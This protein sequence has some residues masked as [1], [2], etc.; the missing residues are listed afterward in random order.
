MTEIEMKKY[1][2]NICSYLMYIIFIPT[3]YLHD[4]NTLVSTRSIIK[5]QYKDTDNI[6]NLKFDT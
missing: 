4:Y 3:L 2:Y 6:D 1:S 5:N